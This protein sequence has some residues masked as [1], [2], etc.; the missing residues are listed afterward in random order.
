MAIKEFLYYEDQASQALD[1]LFKIKATFIDHGL[2]PDFAKI[3]QKRADALLASSKFLKKSVTVLRQHKKI[4]EQTYISPLEQLP[5]LTAIRRHQTNAIKSLLLQFPNLNCATL[6][7]D[8]FAAPVKSDF[9]REIYEKLRIGIC[10]ANLEHPY[11]RKLLQENPDFI[12]EIYDYA[13]TCAVYKQNSFSERLSAHE[14]LAELQALRHDDKYLTK[15]TTLSDTPKK[16]AAYENIV[17]TSLPFYTKS[18]ET[19]GATTISNAF[20]HTQELYVNPLTKVSIASLA[21]TENGRSFLDFV[22]CAV[23]PNMTVDN[24]YIHQLLSLILKN[25]LLTQKSI[26]FTTDSPRDIEKRV[27]QA[28]REPARIQC[29]NISDAYKKLL[30]RSDEWYWGVLQFLHLN[31]QGKPLPDITKKG[32]FKKTTKNP[33]P[34]AFIPTYWGASEK[35]EKKQLGVSPILNLTDKLFIN[36]TRA[37]EMSHALQ[38]VT[39][40]NDNKNLPQLIDPIDLGKPENAEIKAQTQ[41][42]AEEDDIN[43]EYL[44]RFYATRVIDG[45][46]VSYATL[47]REF[48]KNFKREDEAKFFKKFVFS[49]SC[50]YKISEY[51]EKH[52]SELLPDEEP[53]LALGC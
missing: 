17:Y 12:A 42:L 39:L 52:K 35:D 43:W 33:M 44:Q 5:Y 14:T 10:P 30:Q 32:F 46:P 26:F 38:Q 48:C 31:H 6:P 25:N 47:K 29:V 18:I 9:G 19:Q 13:K 1:T 45:I 21:E 2:F 23:P 4:S 16:D 51:F 27:A 8:A 22:R 28:K 50:E 41:K 36:D 40:F 20:L 7:P 3:S 15:L 49:G 34:E 53:V 11:F 24:P 37:D